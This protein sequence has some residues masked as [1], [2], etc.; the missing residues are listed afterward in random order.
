MDS[1]G[2]KYGRLICLLIAAIITLIPMLIIYRSLP[3]LVPEPIEDKKQLAKYG[4][5]VLI[6]VAIGLLI[7]VALTHSGLIA[8]SSGFERASDTLTDGS[9]L[10]KILC[11]AIAVPILE[12]LVVRGILAGQLCLWYGSVIAVALSS[13]CFGILHNNIVQFLYALLVGIALGVLYVKT[14]RLSLCIL[15]HG[16][17]NLIVIL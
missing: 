16:L 15:A 3:K 5:Y 17:I 12:E 4:V 13:I 8:K 14:K 1:I 6:V 7:N 10:I 2:D 9:L 11:N